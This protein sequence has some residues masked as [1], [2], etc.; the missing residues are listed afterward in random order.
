MNAN[1]IFSCSCQGDSEPEKRGQLS[2][3]T[4]M[5]AG[6]ASVFFV[7]GCLSQSPSLFFL[8]IVCIMLLIYRAME[9]VYGRRI[10]VTPTHLQVVHS[11]GTVLQSIVLDDVT[12]IRA[13]GNDSLVIY[14]R[15]QIPET[16]ETTMKAYTFSG[17]ADCAG[18]AAALKRQMSGASGKPL[19]TA[20]P[21]R[22]ISAVQ[23]M[24]PRLLTE[25]EADELHAAQHLFNQGM[26]SEQ[27]FSGVMQQSA[28]LPAPLTGE[29]LNEMN[30][31]DY[32]QRQELLAQQLGM[33]QTEE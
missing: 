1:V 30:A 25:D 3:K 9:P 33:T 15:T 13:A 16:T 26:I 19:F 10:Q 8:T 23:P 12:A 5:T 27:Q 2:R 32:L 7:A 17:I 22:Q 14:A 20:E 4:L 24:Q 31:S 28:P 6:A 11:D 21:A 18:L 29:E